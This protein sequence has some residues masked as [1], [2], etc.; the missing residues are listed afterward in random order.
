[1]HVILSS[2]HYSPVARTHLVESFV[3]IG[4]G[5]CSSKFSLKYLRPSVRS[6]LVH[7]SVG[8]RIPPEFVRVVLAGCLK[9]AGLRTFVHTI[10]LILLR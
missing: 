4:E 2:K 3:R 5:Q 6:W 7:I 9:A 10:P 1:M 8:E